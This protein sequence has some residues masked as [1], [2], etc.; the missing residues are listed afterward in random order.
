MGE[1]KPLVEKLTMP[2]ELDD[3]EE[4]V[5]VDMQDDQEDFEDPADMIEKLGA[6]G[7]AEFFVKAQE[8][9]ETNKSKMPEDDRPAP[10]KA[11]EWKDLMDAGL[12][13]EGEE[14]DFLQES[15]E[16]EEGDGDEEED[17]EPAAKK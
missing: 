14:E 9:F 11:S 6:K 7:T 2:E 13:M 12:D 10:M 3:E 15:E 1:L 8:R 4:V 16:E 17:G 5:P